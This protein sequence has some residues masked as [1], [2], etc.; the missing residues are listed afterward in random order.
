MSCWRHP[1]NNTNVSSVLFSLAGELLG[2]Q[3]YKLTTSSSSAAAFPLRILSAAAPGV[4]LDEM[5][6]VAS[7]PMG[8]TLSGYGSISDSTRVSGESGAPPEPDDAG[9]ASAMPALH[10][11]H[12]IDR[13][14]YRRVYRAG[15]D[16]WP[17]RSRA[18]GGLESIKPR[19]HILTMLIIRRRCI[20]VLFD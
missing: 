2:K 3:E 4:S 6:R 5:A 1:T 15:T 10:P 14:L 13:H 8:T 17:S 12:P 18:H 9:R 11:I 7:S 19:D 16:S 20:A